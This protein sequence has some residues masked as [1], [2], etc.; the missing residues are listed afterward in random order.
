MI[1]LLFIVAAGLLFF[2]A[3]ILAGGFFSQPVSQPV[4]VHRDQDYK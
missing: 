4:R 2:V 1:S 3:A